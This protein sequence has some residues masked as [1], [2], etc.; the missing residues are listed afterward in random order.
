MSKFFKAFLTLVVFAIPSVT[1]ATEEAPAEVAGSVLI[2]LDRAMTLWEEESVFLDVRPASN[3]EAGRIPGAVNLYVNEA[4][5]QDS[6]S[7]VAPQEAAVV[8]YCNGVKCGLSAKAIPMLVG[9]GYTQ[10]YYMRD[11]YPGWKQAGFPVE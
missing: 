8:V 9:W 4:L 2:D 11:G 6:M 3:F 7:E 10:I 1:A 5:N